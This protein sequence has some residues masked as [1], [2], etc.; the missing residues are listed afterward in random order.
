MS[1]GYGPRFCIGASLARVEL[2]AVFSRLF[3]RFPALRTTV[4]V[5]EL[6]RNEGRITEGPARL[7]VTW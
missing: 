6:P 4:P 1:F 5:D 2:V 7:P 3:Q